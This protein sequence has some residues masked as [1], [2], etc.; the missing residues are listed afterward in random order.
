MFGT[1]VNTYF[2]SNLR[3]MLIKVDDLDRIN[4]DFWL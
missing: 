3:V 1:R 2:E 4:F